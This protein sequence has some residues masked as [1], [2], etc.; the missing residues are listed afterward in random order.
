MPDVT[1]GEPRQ[2]RSLHVSDL[3]D[4]GGAEA[5]YADT[6]R[7][8]RA[9]G[10]EVTTLVSDGQRTALGYLFSR[11]WYR[12]MR[13][14]LREADPDLV[15]L[16]NYYRFL[17]PSV[18]LAIRHHRRTHPRLRVVYTA[19]DYHLACPNSGLQ[20]FPHGRRTTFDLG[21]PQIPT[22]ARYDDRTVV[23]SVLKALEHVLAYR[24][25]G[26]R[27][28]L[29]LVLAPSEL[30]RDV[31]ARSGVTV[32][33]EVV[34]NPVHNEPVAAEVSSVDSAGDSRPDVS[35]VYLGRIAPEKGLEELVD[36]LEEV[37]A[38]PAV[39]SIRLDVYGSGSAVPALTRKVRTLRHVDV[40][41][42]P[43]V[44]RRRVSEVVAEHDAFVYPSI[45][46]ENAPISV[47]EAI[48]SGLPVLV[49][50]GTGA[51][52]VARLSEQFVEFDPRDVESVRA[53]LAQLRTFAGRNRLRD[54]HTFT[55][56]AFQEHLGRIY[57]RLIGTPS[58]AGAGEQS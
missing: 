11:R 5:V 54:P 50:R 13:A 56:E 26:L 36:A 42:L 40:R 15:H 55:V 14:T 17:S 45:W 31:L 53:G 25:L 47:V 49:S 30:L 34:R 10:H 1:E 20:H 48:V 4:S 57:T 7:A 21:D 39:G 18:L 22:F 28:E 43:R 9:L 32:D 58:R 8:A 35:L 12:Q 23:H 38:D 29:D 51:A 41:L 2:V 37:A 3:T 19:H 27:S 44:P 16:Q 33:S 6:V 52:E 46:P 24:V